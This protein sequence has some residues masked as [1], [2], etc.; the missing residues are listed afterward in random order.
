MAAPNRSYFHCAV[1]C[2]YRPKPTCWLRKAQTRWLTHLQLCCRHT[3]S[4]PT[5]DLPVPYCTPN[6]CIFLCLSKVV[7]AWRHFKIFALPGCYATYVGSQRR[8]ENVYL[9]RLQESSIL[10]R[11]MPEDDTDILRN[12]ILWKSF[13]GS[14]VV[15]CGRTDGQTYMTKVSEHSV[16]SS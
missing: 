15:L 3:S 16:P 7:N 5:L 9:S 4:T 14:L 13:S 1:T 11:L 8:F 6:L 2:L 12:Q 10:D